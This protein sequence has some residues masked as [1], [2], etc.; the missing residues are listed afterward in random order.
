[1]SF[2]KKLKGYIGDRNKKLDLERVFC[3]KVAWQEVN[4]VFHELS[5]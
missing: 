1:M 2:A 4:Y 5:K 3:E